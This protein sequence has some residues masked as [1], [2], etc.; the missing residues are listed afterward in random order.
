MIGRFKGEYRFLS[1]FWPRPLTLDG[2]TYP[3]VEHAY[4]AAKTLD[5]QER[6]RIASLAT[7]K[8]AKQAGGR[9]TLRPDWGEHVK[10]GIMEDLVRRKFADPGLAARLLATGVE[11]LVEGNTWNDRFWGVCRGVGRNELGRILMRVRSELRSNAAP[12]RG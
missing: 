4:Q 9:V 10:L 11:E 6:T 3:T 8:M 5:P 1:N 12:C 7:P 2:I